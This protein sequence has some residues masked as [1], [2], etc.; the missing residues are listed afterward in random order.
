MKRVQRI[1][2]FVVVKEREFEMHFGGLRRAVERRFVEINRPEIIAL[3][4]LPIR[5]FDQPRVPR[6][7][8]PVAR[9]DQH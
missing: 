7:H 5:F 8:H 6:S 4:R 2:H 9:A 1:V 3:G